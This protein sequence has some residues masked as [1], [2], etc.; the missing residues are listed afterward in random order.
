[1]KKFR[2]GSLGGVS[3]EGKEVGLRVIS[4]AVLQQPSG[5]VIKSD[6]AQFRVN[7]REISDHTSGNANRNAPECAGSGLHVANKEQSRSGRGSDHI[8]SLPLV[9]A[10]EAGKG[11]GRVVPGLVYLLRTLIEF[12]FCN[13]YFGGF[14]VVING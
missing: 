1:M 10:G 14:V 4:F 9:F 12:I 7:V 3:Y 8:G 13:C 6:L 5:G 2:H 11:M